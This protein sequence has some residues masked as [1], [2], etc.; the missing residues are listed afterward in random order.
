MSHEWIVDVLGDLRSFADANGLPKL[1]TCLD[2]AAAVA[3]DE[4]DYGRGGGPV[5]GH[6]D[7]EIRTAHRGDR[8]CAD[9]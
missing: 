6:V 2:V 1:R 3:T 7:G 8:R 5:T 9:A 4:I